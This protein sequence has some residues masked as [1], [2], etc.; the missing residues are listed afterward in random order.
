MRA[1]WGWLRGFDRRMGL[2]G[3][4]LIL[5]GAALLVAS[6]D[7]FVVVLGIAVVS[8]GGAAVGLAVILP[9]ARVDDEILRGIEDHLTK[10]HEALRLLGEAI[11]TGKNTVTVP[12][13]LFRDALDEFE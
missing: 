7:W 9:V 1:V 13:D 6:E 8:A 2:L 11:D 5:A 4:A 3:V 10:Q 12:A